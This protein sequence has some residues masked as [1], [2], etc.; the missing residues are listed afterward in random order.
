MKKR[1]LLLFVSLSLFSFAEEGGGSFFNPISDICWNCMFPFHVAGFN[2]TPSHKDY[3]KHDDVFC[4]CQGGVVGLPVAYWQPNQ[5]CEVTMTPYQLVA[6]GGLQL[7]EPSLKKRGYMAKGE[8]GYF[9][10]LYHV[11]FYTYPVLYLID[12]VANFACVGSSPQA[13]GSL[14]SQEGGLGAR[15][16]IAIGF[17][18]EFD[19]FWFDDAWNNLLYPEIMIFANPLAIAACLPDCVLSTLHKPTNKMFWCSGCQGSLFPFHG[20]VSHARGGVQ[21][22]SLL[23]HRTLAKLHYLG[24]LWSYPTGK[25]KKKYCE[26][27]YSKYPPKTNYKIQLAKPVKQT[28]KKCP[29]L[30]A[31]DFLW[32]AG[33]TYPGQKGEEFVYVIWNRAH[34]CVDPYDIYKKTQ[35]G[36]AF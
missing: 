17:M 23:V 16:T 25:S 9:K 35:T 1:L 20:F 3:L 28:Q 14:G 8:G 5:I 6:F 33:K 2:L 22:S 27:A 19:P 31:S 34:C 30:G 29:A 24:F 18:S 26:T 32:G 12:E 7:A 4:H 15:K 13:K 21:A 10:A 36:G 11:H